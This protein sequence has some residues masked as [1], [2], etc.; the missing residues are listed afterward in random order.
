MK[1]ILI[2]L[3]IVA[4]LLG[5]ALGAKKMSPFVNPSECVGCSD[6]VQICPV[7]GRNGKVAI[8]IVDGKAIINPDDCIACG[9]CVQVCS[10]KAVRQ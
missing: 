2:A 6:C 8:E 10:F 5:G 1:K 3:S 9:L 4:L 7:N